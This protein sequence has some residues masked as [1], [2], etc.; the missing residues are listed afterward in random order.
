[1]I[2]SASR[3]TDIPSYYSEW[4]FNRLKEGYVLVRNPMNPRQI[5]RVNL[6]PEVVDGIVFWTKNPAPMLKKLDPLEKYIYYFQ[7]TVTAYG[8]DIETNLP[9]KNEV[10]IPAFQQ[11]SGEI[12]KERVVWRYDPIFINDRYTLEYHCRSFEILASKL[13]PY[14]EK[15]TISFIDF[16]RKTERSMKR[17]GIQPVS[18]WQQDELLERF[19]KTA[20]KYN[21]YLDACAEISDFRRFGIAP[22]RCIDPERLE[23]IGNYRLHAGKDKNQRHECGCIESIDI[24]TY[25]ACRNG[26]LYCYAN[27]SH[28]IAN[29]NYERHN[30]TSPLLFGIPGE[31]DIIKER[32]VKSCADRQMTLLDYTAETT[33][34]S[35]AET[36]PPA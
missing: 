20:A 6:S 25:D 28:T 35:P 16:Y 8:S 5:S 15:C 10:I 23:K 13:A 26:C 3:R 2:I 34:E 1:M 36:L 17:L 14:T 31:A 4:F 11:L 19:T 33:A 12:G 18:A 24:G 9:S 7:F 30:C 21:I 32:C 29:R 27:H 22:A